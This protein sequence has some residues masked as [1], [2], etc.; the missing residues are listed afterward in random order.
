LRT[1]VIRRLLLMLPTLLGVA[2]IV[3]V[4]VRLIPGDPAEVML[5]GFATEERAAELRKELGLDKPVL[6]QFVLWL[7][8]AIR[9]DL[10]TSIINRR[11]VMTQLAARFP[12]TLELTLI[13]TLISVSVGIALGIAS[14]VR[15]RTAFDLVTTVTSVF[16]MS[17]P[18]FW[19]ALML[20]Y[21]FG[22]KGHLLPISGRV[23]L[24]VSLQPVTGLLI[25]DS[26]LQRDWYALG[27][28]LR[29]IV[30]PAVCL[31][32]IPL[33]IISR[34]TKASMLEVL[35]Q[36]YM[37]A[38]RAKGLPRRKL[39]WKHALRNALLP[40]LTVIGIRFGSQLA[41]AVLVEVVFAWPGVGRLVFESV[42]FR[43][44]PLLQGCIVFIAVIFVFV[45]FLTDMLYAAV[46]PR[47]RYD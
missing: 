43:D 23:G 31:A 44:Y 32:V 47:I 18:I 13:S 20:L 2:I 10:G 41:G 33:A 3:F 40:V 46:D 45:N 27:D 14:A 39:L 26:V 1:Y 35:R 19:L 12:A 22:V 9:G 4:L 7:G 42:Q 6:T 36:D 24:D 16:G 28:V 25:L 21:L 15:H 11:P 17:V 8:R 37:T 29:H 5:G 38:A 30:L 34:I